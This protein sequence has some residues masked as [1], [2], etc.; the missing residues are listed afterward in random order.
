[1]KTETPT[2]TL[3]ESTEAMK[4]IKETVAR[5]F[6]VAVKEIE[7][8]IRREPLPMIRHVAMAL[9]YDLIEFITLQGIASSFNRSEHQTVLHAIKATKSRCEISPAFKVRFERV[10]K[11]AQ[12]QLTKV[13]K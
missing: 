1:M 13:S 3:P 10:K 9:C 7:G 5:E 12:G 8:D 4:A 2:N 6:G 11:A